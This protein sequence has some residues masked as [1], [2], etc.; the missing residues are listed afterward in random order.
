MNTKNDFIRLNDADPLVLKVS[1]L[2]AFLW[3]DFVR[4]SMPQVKYIEELYDFNQ[5]SRFGKE[6]FD[7]MYN[8]GEVTTVISLEDVETYF[9]AKQ[10][11]AE[12]SYPE[13]Y[14]PENS[15]WFSIFSEIVQSAVWSELIEYSVGDQFTSGNNATSILND[16][17]EL[18][19]KQISEGTLPADFGQFSEQL[20]KIRQEFTEA[21]ESG[22]L[23]QAADKRLEG[24][25]LVKQIESLS[26]K[27]AEQ[28]K[29]EIQMSV[30]KAHSESKD[31]KDALNQLAGDQP[32]SGKHLKD[33]EEKKKLARKLKKN[34]NLKQLINRLGSLRTAWRERKRAVAARSNY[35]DIVGAKFSDEVIKA[36]PTELALA[37]TDEGKALFA[38]KYAQKTIL[39]KDFEAKVKNLDKG[40]VVLYVDISGSMMGAAETWSKAISVVIAEE[41]L[42]QGREV[43]IHLFDTMVQKSVTLQPDRKDNSEL[44]DFVVSWVTQGGTSFGS[45]IDHCL[46]RATIDDRAD[47]LMITDGQATVPDGFVKRIKKFKELKGIQWSAFVIGIEDQWCHK[48]CDYVHE[49]DITCD[50]TNAKLFQESLR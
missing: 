26:Q 29:P 14:R 43:Q 46:T 7:Y 20:E 41:C 25:E 49:I 1:S 27:A 42:E 38:L 10:D 31:L 47:I 48:F 21:K 39:S 12:P 44:I 18:I 40:P 6:L 4:D 2:G 8:G 17:S 34:R 37:G 11:G 30:E 22:D 23:Q 13:G 28:L 36:F 5:L 9:R 16:L 35:S 33:V 24:K 50:P 19:H 15:L 32:G 3:E 45:V